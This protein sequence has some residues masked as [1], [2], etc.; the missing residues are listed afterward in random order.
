MSDARRAAGAA[1]RAPHLPHRGRRP[2]GAARRRSD[3]CAPAR[4]SRWWRR[5]APANRRCCIS[6]DCWNG[7]TAARCSSRAATPA[8][9][10]DAA[11]TAIRRDTIGFVYQFH[12]LLGEFTALEN[13]VLP[14]MIAGRSRR[15]AAERAMALLSAHSAWR[16]APGICPASCPAASSSAWRSRAPWPTRRRCCWPTS[17]PATS[18]SQPRT[19]CS[20]NCWRRCAASGVAALIATHNPD[21]A[22]R[23]DRTVTLRDGMV[24]DGVARSSVNVVSRGV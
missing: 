1:R 8:A 12:H 13:V 20:R 16:R 19:W 14:Q 11:R 3:A 7:R 2:A 24:V 23:M 6:P 22:A 18:M 17:R 9:L 15:A 4:S 21:L 10:P 5:R